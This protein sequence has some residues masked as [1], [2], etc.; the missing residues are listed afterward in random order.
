MSRWVALIV[1]AATAVAVLAEEDGDSKVLVLDSDNFYDE[2]FEKD[3]VLVEFYA[4]W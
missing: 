1:F 4:P 3:I 2:L